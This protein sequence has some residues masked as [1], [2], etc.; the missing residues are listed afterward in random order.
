M[1]RSV[2]SSGKRRTIYYSWNTFRITY[3]QEW[4]FLAQQTFSRLVQRVQLG[5]SPWTIA[6]VREFSN[7]LHLRLPGLKRLT[8]GFD[9]FSGSWQHDATFLVTYMKVL[10]EPL[11]VN[12]V[13]MEGN[14]SYSRPEIASRVLDE[15]IQLQCQEEVMEWLSEIVLDERVHPAG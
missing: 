9:D 6:L 15:A 4:D 10:I 7:K 12:E 2:G 13:V 8:A 1:L 11:N 5:I 3:L 14:W